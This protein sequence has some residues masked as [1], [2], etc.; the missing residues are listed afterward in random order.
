MALWGKPEE[1]YSTSSPNSLIT[2]RGRAHLSAPTARRHWGVS[3]VTDQAPDCCWSLPG[4][5]TTASAS[6]MVYFHSSPF[7][8]IRLY[9]F[10]WQTWMASRDIRIP[11]IVFI[12][13]NAGVDGPVSAVPY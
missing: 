8:Q 4:V 2:S 7:E 12:H 1:G 9:L 3:H 6:K 5:R 10:R 13:T 11:I